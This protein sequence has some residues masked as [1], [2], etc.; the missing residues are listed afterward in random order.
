MLSI[1]GIET[2][3]F[4]RIVIIPQYSFYSILNVYSITGLWLSIL[5]VFLLVT[6]KE[7]KSIIKYFLLVDTMTEIVWNVPYILL[8]NS[9]FFLH[10]IQVNPIWIYGAIFNFTVF[11][12]ILILDRRK[13]K[14][15]IYSGIA[16]LIYEI[17]YFFVFRA[18]IYNTTYFGVFGSIPEVIIAILV[19]LFLLRSYNLEPD[20]SSISIN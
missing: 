15:D 2:R 5:G 7:P 10:A 19:S 18:P 9:S 1:A 3:P 16:L 20:K 17:I 6:K 13:V 11:P 12:L 8:I 14:F 4:G